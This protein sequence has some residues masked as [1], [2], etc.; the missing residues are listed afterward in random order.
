MNFRSVFRDAVTTVVVCTARP[1]VC[2][3]SG[4]VFGVT[5]S[6]TMAYYVWTRRGDPVDG[7]RED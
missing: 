1:V 2:A 3:A 4:I 5:A 7:S 6:V